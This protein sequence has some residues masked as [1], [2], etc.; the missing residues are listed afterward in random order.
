MTPD[1]NEA[2]FTVVYDSEEGEVVTHG[3]GIHEAIEVRKNMIDQAVRHAAV[4][5]LERLGYTI[6]KPGA[7]LTNYEYEMLGL[8]RGLVRLHGGWTVA[9]INELDIDDLLE[10]A[11][12]ITEEQS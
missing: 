9:E 11:R 10:R 3:F 5:E 7:A 4:V 12:H 6:T 8:I 1:P 2:A